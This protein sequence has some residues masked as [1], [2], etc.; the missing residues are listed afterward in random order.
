MCPLREGAPLHTPTKSKILQPISSEVRTSSYKGNVFPC[1]SSSDWEKLMQPP[2]RFKWSTASNGIRRAEPKM[3]NKLPRDTK[4]ACPKTTA[5]PC[6]F[7]HS[8]GGSKLLSP[9]GCL[10]VDASRMGEHTA[11]HRLTTFD[12]LSKLKPALNTAT[13]PKES[14]PVWLLSFY[15]AKL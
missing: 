11:H 9:W 13:S 3:P 10:P 2:C 7:T 12:K 5:A 14:C 4:N 6:E 8:L 15:L 1:G